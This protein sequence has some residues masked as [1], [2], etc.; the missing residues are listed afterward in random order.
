M[1]LLPCTFRRMR[2]TCLPL[3][4][5]CLGLAAGAGA[6]PTP[7]PAVTAPPVKP[8][9][10]YG[11]II[12][13]RGNILA[14]RPS[15]RPK[16]VRLAVS[17]KTEVAD[18]ARADRSALK[19][20]ML[21]AMEGSY[22]E[23]SGFQPRY[24]DAGYKRIGYLSQTTKG[25]E[26]NPQNH[27]AVC[28]GTLKSLTPFVFTDDLGKDHTASL[29]QV[30]GI[31]LNTPAD[32]SGLLIGLRVFATGVPAPDGVIQAQSISPDRDFAKAGTMFATLLGVGK[33]AAGQTVLSVRPR[34]TTDSLDV[35]CADAPTLLR[36]IAVDPDS[37]P[38]GATVTFWGFQHNHP[39]DRPRTEALEAIALLIGQDR[40][41]AA[42]TGSAGGVFL[43]GRLASLDPVTLALPN[44]KHIPIVVPG[45]MMVAR[46]APITVADLTPGAELMLVI[47]RRPDGGFG[48]DT[49]IRDA[50]P[51]VGYGG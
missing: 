14:V 4:C 5:L 29:D 19:P 11:T 32:P 34:F 25:I 6:D 47:T 41:P 42:A 8:V 16:L 45:Q 33:N 1:K 49:I 40:Y 27:S 51:F 24:M 46:L 36:Q 7:A 26:I 13:V 9:E 37:V 3:V 17:D 43:T 15:L 39:W 21:L 50:P 48:T 20:G 31:W 18:E 23:K 35:V 28:S 38:V 12:S 10:V 30:R 44:G 2:V 22:S